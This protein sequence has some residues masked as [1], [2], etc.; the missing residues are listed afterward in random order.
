M[1]PCAIQKK[2][3]MIFRAS[4][5]RDTTVK[6]GLSNTYS[7]A[8]KNSAKKIK[9]HIGVESKPNLALSLQ[10]ESFSS[11]TTQRE[12]RKVALG[13]KSSLSVSQKNKPVV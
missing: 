9:K 1:V 5:S 13:A 2:M 12:S 4:L 10:C 8:E 3:R 11:E 6:E 7:C